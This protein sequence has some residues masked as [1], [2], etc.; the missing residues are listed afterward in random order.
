MNTSTQEIVTKEKTLPTKQIFNLAIQFLALALLLA[1]CFQILAPFISVVMWAA[2]L[3]VAL[4]PFHQK[5]KKLLKQ[6]GT[7]AAVIITL[8]SLLIIIVPAVWLGVSTAKEVKE[9]ATEYG[10]GHVNIPPP[11]ARKMRMQKRNWK[12]QTAGRQMPTRAAAFHASSRTLLRIGRPTGRRS[13]SQATIGRPPGTR[14]SKRRS[15]ARSNSVRTPTRA[16]NSTWTVPVA[17]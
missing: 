1:W 6:R 10:A 4:Y 7:L 12:L 3:A 5:L 16:S 2:I 13:G 9:F 14:S 15:R 17:P 8:I 11:S